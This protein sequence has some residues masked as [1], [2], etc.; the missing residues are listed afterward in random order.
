VI[1]VD[2]SVAV[3]AFAS[4]HESHMSAREAIRDGAALIAHCAL[5]TYSVLTRLPTP[6]RAPGALVQRFL[7]VQFS[8][9]HLVLPARDQRRLTARLVDLGIEGGA[10]YDGLVALTAASAGAT[11]ISLDRRAAATYERCGV[12]VRLVAL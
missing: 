12:D 1:A 5:E 2:T 3:A 4:W 8:L 11:L 7:A 6:H 10:V 9:P